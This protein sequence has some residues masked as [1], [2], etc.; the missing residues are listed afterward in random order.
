MAKYKYT[1]LVTSHDKDWEIVEEMGKKGH[2]LIHVR[3]DGGDVIYYF[4]K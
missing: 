1:K 3:S 4:K 2:E